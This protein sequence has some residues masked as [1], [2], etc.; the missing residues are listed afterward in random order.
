M[1]Q[2]LLLL[3]PHKV[4][5]QEN[6]EVTEFGEELDKK[7]VVMASV[8]RA[9]NGVG[10]AAPQAGLN[11]QICIAMIDGKM[12]ELIN[13]KLDFAEDPITSKEGCLSVPGYNDFVKRFNKIGVTFKDKE[14]TSKYM[15]LEGA[16]AV[17]VQHEL[18]HLNGVVFVDKLSNMKKDFALARVNKLRRKYGWN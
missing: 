3:W 2:A 4:L 13:P 9:A 18:D 8:M 6:A 16:N 10:I 7:L 1:R 15:E 14:G 12:Q 5:K 11:E 17:V